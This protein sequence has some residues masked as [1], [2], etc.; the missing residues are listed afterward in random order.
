M[1]LKT[2]YKIALARALQFPII[3]LRKMVGLPMVVCVNR[4]GI[5]WLLN[6]NEGIDFS[7]FLTGKFEHRTVDAIAKFVEAGDTVIDI[8][9]NIGAHSLPV[10]KLVGKSGRV[11]ALEPTHFA[12]EKLNNNIKLNPE[13][14]SQILADQVMLMGSPNSKLEA[15]LYSSWPL[16]KKHQEHKKHCGK[17]QSTEGGK[18]STLT[19]YIFSHGIEDVKLVKIDVD[20]FEIEVLRGGIDFFE[21][22]KPTI[23]MELAPYTLDEQ[24]ESL[25][26]LINIL[27]SAGYCLH[28]Q[29]N[30][31]PLSHDPGV[32]RSIIPDGGSINVVASIS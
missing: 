7:I 32:L 15:E 19:D 5:R 13:L 6:L 21:N 12:F 22:Q 2:K 9:A 26:T 8:G 20:G 10:A 16:A 31:K 23:V 28:N 29:D 4:N 18:A 1:L 27:S 14:S 30:G 24:G 11:I 25:E 17:L 3:I